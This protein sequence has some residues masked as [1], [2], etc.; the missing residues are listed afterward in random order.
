MDLEHLGAPALAFRFLDWYAEFSGDHAPTSLVEHYLAYRVFARAKVECVRHGQGIAVAGA[1]ARRF[2]FAA[3]AH[4]QRGAVKLVLVGGA[5]ATGKSTI[6]AGVADRLG[7]TLLSSDRVRKELA[8]MSPTTSAMARMGEGIYTPESTG[9]V[10]GELM[11]CDV[12]KA[13]VNRRGGLPGGGHRHRCDRRRQREVPGF[14]VGDSGET[15]PVFADLGE[16]LGE[17]RCVVGLSDSVC[18]GLTWC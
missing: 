6:G 15:L 9:Q 10:Y 17:P 4:L 14:D 12:G 5:P 11:R 8:H 3:F 2:A 7:M 1:Q 13:R 18:K 16:Q